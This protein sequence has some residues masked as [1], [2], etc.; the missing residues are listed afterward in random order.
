MLEIVND[1]FCPPDNTCSPPV[2]KPGICISQRLRTDLFFPR[3][4]GRDRRAEAPAVAAYPAACYSCFGCASD[5]CREMTQA[6][7]LTVD[8][9]LDATGL[10]CP[11]PVLK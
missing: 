5:R 9:T 4:R 3:A 8:A 6:D 7:N 10:L 11:L 2:P 1:R